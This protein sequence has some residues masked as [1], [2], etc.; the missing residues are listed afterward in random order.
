MIS[1]AFEFARDRV[2][3]EKTIE[4]IFIL[5][6]AIIISLILTV[7]FYNATDKV[8]A[9][10]D[11]YVPLNQRILAV[12]TNPS[13]LL[14]GN[15]TIDIKDGV[16][17][18]TVENEECK[19]TGTYDRE[20]KLTKKTQSDKAFSTVSLVIICCL[21]LGGFSFI[22]YAAGYSA[23]F[24]VCLII[25]IGKELVEKIKKYKQEKAL[26]QEQNALSEESLSEI[27]KD[28]DE[29]FNDECNN[30]VGDNTKKQDADSFTEDSV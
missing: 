23:I 6:L 22:F 10:F 5:I 28:S 15:G 3:E 4:K 18:Y 8:P 7:S 25:A 12:E 13:S 14:D 19:M 20:Y 1:K 11:D 21:F 24:I 17:T 26:V 2:S 16:I 27:E 29:Q 30:D 9:T